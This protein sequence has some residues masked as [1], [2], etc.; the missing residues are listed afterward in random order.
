M[1][2]FWV[3]FE[4]SNFDQDVVTAIN[5]CIEASIIFLLQLG[6][7]SLDF[8]NLKEGQSEAVHWLENI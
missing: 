6:C 5:F 7:Y 2:N 1:S 8:V 3:I 4:W